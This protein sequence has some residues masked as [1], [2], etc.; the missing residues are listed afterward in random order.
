MLSAARLINSGEKEV[1]LVLRCTAGVDDGEAKE[2][3]R[4]RAGAPSCLAVSRHRL[5]CSLAT[6]KQPCSLDRQDTHDRR[7]TLH[8]EDWGVAG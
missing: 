7:R 5:F 4:E 1:R 2:W 3:K 6:S 8:A